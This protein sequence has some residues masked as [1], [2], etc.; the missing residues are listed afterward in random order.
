MKLIFVN[1]VYIYRNLMIQ[2][3]EVVLLEGAFEFLK[4]LNL[5]PRKKIL[6][7]MHRAKYNTDPKL[8][9]KPE[10]EIW[11]F[12][13]LFAGIQYRLLAFWDKTNKM[14]TIVFVT[15][16]VIKKTSKINK[17]EIEKA[18]HIRQD[19]FKSK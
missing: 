3:F 19:Y 16:G 1:A 4:K 14:E 5:K 10:G 2:R 13:T 7:N 9:K 6:Q 18:E 8:L 15:H 11:E 17:K 12:R